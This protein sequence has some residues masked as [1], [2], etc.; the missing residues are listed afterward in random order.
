M[1]WV[2]LE[3][4]IKLLSQWEKAVIPSGFLESTGSRLILDQSA[5]LQKTFCRLHLVESASRR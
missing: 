3:H 2:E 1:T 4:G 5:G